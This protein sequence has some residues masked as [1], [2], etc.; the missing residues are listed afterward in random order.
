MTQPTSTEDRI[1]ETLAELP[2]SSKLV[3]KVLEY[4]GR[5]PQKELADETRLSPRT[6]RYAL[7][8]LEDVGLVES[9]PALYDARETC[10]TRVGDPAGSE[11]A[12]DALV[13]ADW[14]HE[15]LPSFKSDD[16]SARLLY[17]ATDGVA[18]E[19]VPGSVVV[20]STADILD[21]NRQ[22]FPTRTE[23]ENA[24]GTHGVTPETDLVLYDDGV[25][26]YAAYAYWMLAYFGHGAMRLLNG[27]LEHWLDEGF[28][29][30]DSPEP[31]P[32]REYTIRGVFS[33]VRAHRDEVARAL[34]SDTVLLDVRSQ[35]EH[36]GEATEEDD[37]SAV[38]Q[39]RGHIPGATN[40]P[41][42]AVYG[43]DHR[44]AARSDLE[45][46]FADADVTKDR[47]IIVYCGVG[48]RSALVWFVLS[49]LLGYPEVLNY[50]GSWTEWGNLVDVPIET[51]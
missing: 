22:Q 31:F 26:Y 21:P 36:R 30:T 40:I 24:L 27:G 16:P 50:D 29:T 10:Y 12:S 8:Q 37:L 6:L 51:E 2:P 5:L 15:R 35:S 3:Y 46:R 14:V 32:T 11:Y 20:E 13:E 39:S 19:L 48:G 45:E 28:S 1:E 44:F 47:E 38:A 33:R 43:D 34:S 41:W 42:G 25:G 9:R 18:E 4:N 7:S 49:E 23:F 17:I